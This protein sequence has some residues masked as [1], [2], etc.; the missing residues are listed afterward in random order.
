LDARQDRDTRPSK[1][2]TAKRIVAGV[3][4]VVFSAYAFLCFWQ[5]VRAFERFG[6]DFF[7]MLLMF[8]GVVGATICGWFA[9][10]GHLPESRRHIQVTI[11]GGWIVGGISFA[12]GFMGPII[13]TPES[14][15]GPLLGIFLTGPLGFVLGAVIG[16]FYGRFRHEEAR[17]NLA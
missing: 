7:S 1:S 14:N 16:W 11:R 8:Y 6:F 4:A 13:F 2:V 5:L 17:T 15:Q 3:A 12:L 10:R 9:L